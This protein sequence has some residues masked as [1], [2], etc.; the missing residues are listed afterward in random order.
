MFLLFQK[1]N[2][3]KPVEDPPSDN[4]DEPADSFIN[5]SFCQV[6]TPCPLGENRKRFLRLVDDIKNR[7]DDY[8]AQLSSL[9]LAAMSNHSGSGDSEQE[10]IN[11]IF[12][13]QEVQKKDDNEE[14]ELKLWKARLVLKIGE[15]LDQEEEDIAGHLAALK[16]DQDGLFK[17]L[18]GEGDP[19]PGEDNPFAELTQLTEQLGATHHGN[20]KKRYLAWKT[21]FLESNLQDSA[22]FLT[23]S[24]DSG[25]LLQESYEKESGLAASTVGSLALPAIIG[26]DYNEASETALTFQ[27]KHQEL[28]ADMTQKIT[29]LTHM[30]CGTTDAR[31]P[32]QH[33]TDVFARIQVAIDTEFPTE[34]HGRLQATVYMFPGLNGPALFSREMHDD[35]KITNGLLL[36]IS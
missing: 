34:T 16:D 21:L 36:V 4:A 18:H 17:E 2:I 3:I 13:P 14:N 12:A 9:T 20:A 19:L 22:L 30:D 5:S 6:H 11:S 33:L 28:I 25:D 8:A 23:T 27:E 29:E 32:N 15:I 1:I 7:K 35:Q 31:K 26:W 10:I 24:T